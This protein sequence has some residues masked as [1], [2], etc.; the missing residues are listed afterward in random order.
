[1]RRRE[2]ADE[3]RR[4]EY[5]DVE[6]VNLTHDVAELEDRAAA[7]AEKVTAIEELLERKRRLLADI[8]RMQQERTEAEK[9]TRAEE[10]RL[11]F[12]RRRSERLGRRTEGPRDGRPV[13]IDVDDGAWEVLRREAIERRWS[14]LGWVG[15]LVDSEVEAVGHGRVGGSPQS[16]RRRSPGEVEPAPRLRFLRVRVGDD[17]WTAHRLVA[18][19]LGLT[20]ARYLGE[21]VEAEAYRLGWRA[22]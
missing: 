16:R 14:L 9:A 13:R 20:A 2:Q 21:V 22:T 7:E 19:E 18:A 15:E 8:V 3:C 5:L 4:H 10:R 11:E 12:E 17:E 6:L 1:V